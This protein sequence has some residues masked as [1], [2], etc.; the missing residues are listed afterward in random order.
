MM[1]DI[2]TQPQQ[3]ERKFEKYSVIPCQR[4]CTCTIYSLTFA[5][6][7]N[8]EISQQISIFHF[9]MTFYVTL[10]AALKLKES[11]F[12]SFSSYSKQL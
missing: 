4:F 5:N 2:D 10:T 8:V 3:L 9:C 6:G 1:K 7:S 11:H 12:S